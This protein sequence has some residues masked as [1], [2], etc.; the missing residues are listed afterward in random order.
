MAANRLMKM[1]VKTKQL[2][3]VQIAMTPQ[4]VYT[5]TRPIQRRNVLS[6]VRIKNSRRNLLKEF[7]PRKIG[8]IEV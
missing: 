1:D 2:V 5:H 8:N 4:P 3:K 6:S 7:I